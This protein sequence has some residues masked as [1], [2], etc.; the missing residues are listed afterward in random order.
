MKPFESLLLSIGGCATGALLA[1][2]L[3][4]GKSPAPAANTVEP[5]RAIIERRR[6]IV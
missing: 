3:L 4:N 1:I 2:A 6:L 5:P